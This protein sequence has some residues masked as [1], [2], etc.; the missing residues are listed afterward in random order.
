MRLLLFVLV[1]LLISCSSKESKDLIPEKTGPSSIS[2]GY[3]EAP[4]GF[5]ISVFAKGVTNAR[6]MAMSDWGILYVGSRREGKVYAI[7]DNNNDFKADSVYT[8]IEGLRLPNGVAYKDGSLF[9][10]EVSKI[11]RFDNIDQNYADSPEP[12]LVTDELPTE[13]HHGWKYISFG[14]DDKL[15]VPIGAPCNVCNHEEDNPLFATL[16]R[17]NPDGSEH[18]IV[19]KGIRNTVGFTWHPETG[20]IWFTD[21]GRDWLGDDIPPCELNEITGED[22]HFG[23]PYLHGNDVWDPKFGEDGKPMADRFKKPVQELG[24]HVAPLGVIFYTGNMFP[25]SYKNRALIAEHGSWNR[26]SKV[27]YQISQV[28]FDDEGNPTE[29][30][31]FITGWLAGEEDIKGRPVSILQLQDGSLLISDDDSGKIYRVTYSI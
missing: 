13:G 2:L 25:T 3:L 26:S 11:W 5:E 10:A 1:T 8:I 6:Q 28:I 22:Q 31:P 17:M 29:Y 15:Y 7:V 21:N 23:Y 18:E 19:A 20:N 24:A 9:V 14:P 30:K 12:V 16:T 4:A 27:G